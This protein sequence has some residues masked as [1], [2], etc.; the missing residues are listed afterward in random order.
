MT[1]ALMTTYWEEPQSI[2][3]A[4]GLAEVLAGPA[5][6]EPA[7]GAIVQ[8]NRSGGSARP[9][10]SVPNALS[11][12]N[13]RRLDQWGYVVVPDVG[14]LAAAEELVRSVGE[15]IPQYHD[16]SRPW[17][18]RNDRPEPPVTGAS[19][20]LALLLVASHLKV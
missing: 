17:T 14:N 15:L 9:A 2:W 16:L 7:G 10:G 20:G 6:Q 5:A 12:A 19:A 3:Y 4:S 18:S 11:H 1:I 13:Q 8:F